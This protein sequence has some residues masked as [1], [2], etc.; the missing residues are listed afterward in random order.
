MTTSREG[1]F[2]GFIRT[3]FL[4]LFL[5]NLGAINIHADSGSTGYVGPSSSSSVQPPTTAQNTTTTSSN[6][7]GDV[8]IPSVVLPQP[9][10]SSSSDP[11]KLSKAD[12]KSSAVTTKKNVAN[13]ADTTTLPPPVTSTGV[14]A[15]VQSASVQVEPYSGS[16]GLTIPIA[17]PPG[18]AGIQPSLNLIYNSGLRQLGNAGVGWT[19]DLGSIQIS[20]K[21]GVPQYNNADIYTMEQGGSTEDLVQDPNTP[22][23]YHMEVEGSFANIQFVT[24]HWV[25]TDKKGIKYY[26]GNTPDSK[27]N[28]ANNL[29]H[30]F[31]WGLNRV[32][33][34]N[35]NYMNIVYLKDNGQIYP[36][37]ISYTGNDTASLIL[38]TYAVV[39]INYVPTT[40]P[41]TTYIP[42]FLIQTA[43]R[44][45]NITVY[46]GPNIQST[47]TLTYKQSAYSYRDLLQT[48]QQTGS[49]NTSTL[50]AI[51]F[52]Y[53][54][55]ASKGFQPDPTWDL[56]N[57]PVFSFYD[58]SQHRTSWEDLGVRII[59]VNGDGYPDVIQY[60]SPW[61]GAVTNQVSLNSQQKSWTPTSNWPL[62]SADTYGLGFVEYGDDYRFSGLE[63]VD[64]NADGY[65][66]LIQ[67]FRTDISYGGQYIES[68]A[69]NNGINGFVSDSNWTL[70][71]DAILY[72][73]YNEPSYGITSPGGTYFGSITGTGFPD[74]AIARTSTYPDHN[75]YLN[76]KGINQNTRGWT[77]STNYTTPSGVDFTNGAILVDLNGDGLADI[78][79]LVGG[80]AQVYM[81][82]GSGWQQTTNGYSNTLGLGD[83]TN[84]TTEFI[85]V[86]GDGLP[87]MVIANGSTNHVLINTG[88]G[89]IQDDSWAPQNADFTNIGTQ[90]LDASAAGMQDYIISTN[91]TKQIYM[92]QG[93][94]ADLLTGVDNGIGAVTSIQYD[95]IFHYQNTYM[96]YF[97]PVVKSTTTTVDSQSYT[98][99]YNYAGGKWDNNYREFDGFSTVTV[100]DA[101]RNYVT[102]TY[103]QDHWS[104]GHPLEQDTFDA[105][106]NLYS[107]S[108]N[109]WV[110][111]T[112]FTNNT[113]NQTS[114][115][116]YVSRSD[117]Y[118]YD[119]NS[120]NT[121][122]R[123]AQEFT[124]GENP[125]YGDVTQTIN[126][127]QVDPVQGASID[128]NK[129]TTQITYVNNTNNW[130]IGLPSQTITKDINGNTISKQLFYY[131]GDT[132]GS[133]NPSLGRL[134]A[135]INWLGSSAQS[136]PKTTYSYDSYG[137]LKTTTDPNNNTT[138]IIYDNTVHM[139]PEATVNALNQYVWMYYY[140]IDSI[141]LNDG[142]GLQG[143]WGQEKAK[144]DANNQIAY[145]SYDVFG[146]PI[147]SISPL[148]SAA[149]P[150]EQKSYNIQP[151]YMAITDTARVTS[152]SASIISSVTYYDGLGRLIETKSLG[153]N[154]GQYIVS[155]QTVYDNRGLPIKKYLP[156]FTTND[157]STMDSII[158]TIP[159]SQAIYD[160]MGRVITKINPDGTY[161][162]VNYNQ[163][164]TT[165]TDENG[166]QEI[167]MVDAFGRL[168]Q[169]QEFQ[170]AD[171]R[172]PN[173]PLTPF[174]LYAKTNYAYDPK[175]DLI[176]VID[177]H[178]NQTTI[179][180]DNLGR[181]IAM[182][183][184]DMGHW[185]YGYDGNGNLIWQKD[186]KGS[187]ISFK[188]D[189]L[190]RLINKTDGISGPIVGL[191]AITPQAPTFNVTYNFDDLVQSYGIGRLGSVVYDSGTVGFIYDPLGR[192]ISS[193]K[194]IGTGNYNVIRHYDAL[195]RLQQ[196]QYPDGSKANYGYNQAGQLIN[197]TN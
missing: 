27:Q 85:D 22:G 100:I 44:I 48:I 32:E 130:L 58:S 172:S 56:S 133:A 162:S 137:N 15:N 24:D 62:V 78:I 151:T 175:G 146:R 63:M 8:K 31:R 163:W 90:F 145:I 128:S 158:A 144:S 127:G 120:Q 57:V 179:S 64:L 47:Y 191:P 156:H 110:E 4:C 49:D 168:I 1:M 134:T 176:S 102:S 67:N 93:Q 108:I 25:I 122:K 98:T 167:S 188:Y 51:T 66:D 35:G 73:E 82:T 86:N 194:A 150:T 174:S 60:S 104:K 30:I 88:S 101:N 26:Y 14:I 84:G 138:T 29:N 96:P 177:D 38:S 107:K 171:G 94:P 124:Y 160:P 9:G 39:N 91:G 182:N 142:H 79:N 59:D 89:W 40:Q 18:R 164:T 192:E 43:K 147:A 161:S 189:A 106:G 11:S 53:S 7:S 72:Y 80:V 46:V 10:A 180:Y 140:G 42:T 193:N 170:G 20:T 190:N 50:P 87:D 154:S 196:L 115:F 70:P 74:L 28:D 5:S 2:K 126:D 103:L 92:N 181:K 139:L 34:L 117:N 131:D 109:T 76:N 54:D 112:L 187:V 155:G 23:L 123:T 185:S 148:D 113:S 166:H 95:S 153:P 17:V 68:D 55:T 75:V 3:A 118:L 16:S 197:V 77:L 116:L 125:Q 195:N 143:L 6:V 21:N 81:N 157:L 65:P 129:T 69:M 13:P 184:L 119:G 169:K 152:G 165:S 12:P 33:D 71:Q 173:Y 19:L 41:S 97:I 45:D 135:K 141:P 121:P 37:T 61:G 114:K 183:D 36:Q 159:N 178:N 52:S 99:S 186:A 83:L 132:T 105:N 149:L 111:A 136:D